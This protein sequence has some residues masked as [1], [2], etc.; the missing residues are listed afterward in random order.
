MAIEDP[1]S[2]KDAETFLEAFV[3]RIRSQSEQRSRLY[4][5]HRDPSE[6]EVQRHIDEEVESELRSCADKLAKLLMT[7]L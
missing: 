4:G 1:Q 2:A 5:G 7:G 6:E 3:D